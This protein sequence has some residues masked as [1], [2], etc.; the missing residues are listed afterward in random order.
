MKVIVFDT[1]TT[2][3]PERGNNNVTDTTK[4][5]HIIQLSYIGFDTEKKEIFEYS[6][7][8]ILLNP[9]VTI[10]PESIAVHKITRERSEREGIP[11]EQ[12]LAAFRECLKDADLIVAHNINFDKNMLMVECNRR[13]LPNCFMRNGAFIP[14]FCTMTNTI[15][16]C[17]LPNP[18]K[19]YADMGQFKWPSLAELHFKLF[20]SQTKG[21][22]NAIVDVMVCLR[23]Y[24]KIHHQYDIA[25]DLEVKLVFRTL[26]SAYCV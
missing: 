22:H 6:D 10:S 13:G 23:C 3:L 17:Q 25:N 20:Q 1:E 18:V 7:Y 16:L 14:E 9:E 12:V 26:F 8:I 4:W 5:P 24:V 19:K 2:G 15:A 21:A 11:I